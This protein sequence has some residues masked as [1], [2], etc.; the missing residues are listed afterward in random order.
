MAPEEARACL[1]KCILPGAEEE[2]PS[3]ADVRVDPKQSRMGLDY[4]VRKSLARPLAG[5]RPPQ[6]QPAYPHSHYAWGE[7]KAPRARVHALARGRLAMAHPR[8]H[9]RGGEKIDSI[10]PARAHT[11]MKTPSGRRRPR[12]NTCTSSTGS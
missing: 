9:L 7:E 3:Q 4:V 1:A 5:G 10:A 11:C 12:P 8:S 2:S 6:I